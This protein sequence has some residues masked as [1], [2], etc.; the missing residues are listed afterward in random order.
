MMY[1]KFPFSRSFILRSLS[2]VL[3]V[4]L[5]LSSSPAAMAAGEPDSSVQSAAAQSQSTAPAWEASNVY[6]GGDIVSHE[7]KLFQAKWWTQ[8]DNPNGALSSTDSPWQ[9]IGS[10]TGGGTDTTPPSTPPGL[11]STAQTSSS[12]TLTWNASTDNV[13][14]TQYD[15]YRNNIKVGFSAT[16]S[17]TDNGLQADTAYSYTIIALDAAG[18]ASTA[19][20]PL[21]VK[22]AVDNGSGGPFLEVGQ[23]RVITDAQVQATWGGIDPNFLPSQAEAAVTAALSKA[24][25]EALF[26]LRIGSS[27]WHTAAAG[28]PYYK[29]NQEDYY[30]YDNLIAAVRDTANIKYK[31]VY[32][33]GSTWTK[34]IWRL[35]KTTKTET[36]LYEEPEFNAE[37]NLNKPTTSR[38]VDFGTFLK[39]GSETNKKRELA[40]F[41]ANI[42]HETGGGWSTAPGGELRWALFFNEEVSYINNSNIGYVQANSDYPAVA[43][44]SY[45]GRGPIQLS[46]NY[47]YGLIGSI[48][49]G[50]KHVLLQNP[51]KITQEGKLGFMTAILFWMTPQDPK[52]SC[53]DIMVGNYVPTSAQLAKGLVPGFG[54]TIMVINGMYEGNKDESDIRVGRRVGHYLDITSRAGV[55]V[56]GE[57]VNTL[58]MQ[59]F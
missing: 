20:A 1:S 7:G 26:P 22:T 19:S 41:L 45:H 47:N 57:K 44:K 54:A 2:A 28:K 38:I 59:S 6:V 37:W 32:R 3:G 53:H 29:P 14:V 11:A 58:G 43:G 5:L 13:G 25:Y 50:D 34:Q 18:N 15:I 12:I 39:E 31:E 30:S 42:A 55:D 16:T 24:D 4:T 40:A 51:E 48:I 9:H 27:E 52:P 46:W 49:F 56:T 17:Y 21:S 8:G 23:S 35:D 33:G 36:L 10:D